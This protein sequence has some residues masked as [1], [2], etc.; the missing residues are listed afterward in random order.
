[1]PY[2]KNSNLINWLRVMRMSQ[3]FFILSIIPVLMAFLL[4]SYHHKIEFNFIYVLLISLICFLFHLAADMV[5]EYFDFYAGNHQEV[6]VKTPFNGGTEVLEQGLLA[7]KQVLLMVIFCYILGWFIAGILSYLTQPSIFIFIFLGFFCSFFYSA[8]PLKLSY[9]GL[10]EILIFLN[11]GL[12]I[13]CLTYLCFSTTINLVE[14]LPISC[15]LGF[16]GLAIIS[17]NEIPDYNAD[18][19][20]GKKNLVVRMGVLR[21]L[22]LT[23]IFVICS[24][25]SL[26]WAVV[27]G[28]V[29][30]ICLLTGV[31][32]L[33]YIK[34]FSMKI[35]D[36][37]QVDT[38]TIA[39]KRIINLK[40]HSALVLFLLFLL[41]I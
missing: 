23:K 12:F 18:K 33:Y 14:I 40:L 31:V 5:N 20:V 7:T 32:F 10:G 24:L 22:M 25:L 26:F 29:P 9:C 28:N 36:F 19:R 16:L 37:S 1:M 13:F 27:I 17:C 21:T 6:E 4:L 11:N 15:F 39:C 35:D 2:I 41:W 30:S 3:G 34:I 8:P 38:A